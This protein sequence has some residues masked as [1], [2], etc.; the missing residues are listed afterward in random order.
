VRN[1]FPIDILVLPV[2]L[3]GFLTVREVR[4]VPSERM[5]WYALVARSSLPCASSHR[6]NLHGSFQCFET[7]VRLAIVSSL[8]C[9]LSWGVVRH[10]DR[11]RVPKGIKE[12]EYMNFLFAR[13]NALFIFTFV[14]FISWN[15]SV[16]ILC[17]VQ[18][19]SYYQNTL[20]C[21]FH[22]AITSSA[23]LDC[24]SPLRIYVGRY[25]PFI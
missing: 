8:R 19:L 1:E 3:R 23:I 12:C 14:L 18:R 9:I 24:E 13:I 10:T 17:P 6:R 4:S 16:L 22:N 5:G 15:F 11:P 2:L 7:V 20:R 25:N 21:R